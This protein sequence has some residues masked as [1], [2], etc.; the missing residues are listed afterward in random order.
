MHVAV[1][2]RGI[3]REFEEFFWRGSESGW[4]DFGKAD[5]HQA[6]REFA[7]RDR[8]FGGL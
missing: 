7:A 1:P 6:I 3:M 4:P 2:R 8:R 5:L